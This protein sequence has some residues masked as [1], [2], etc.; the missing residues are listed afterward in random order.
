[1]MHVQTCRQ[2]CHIPCT[3][4]GIK[5]PFPFVEPSL[6]AVQR[7]AHPVSRQRVDIIGFGLL[8]KL[9][10]I[11]GRDGLVV[12]P[13]FKSLEPECCQHQQPRDQRDEQP[14][15]K[16]EVNTAKVSAGSRI[17]TGPRVGES[18]TSRTP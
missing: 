14:R 3:G 12:Q 9:E 11:G 1:V 5:R 10:H 13:R 7:A 2:T 16:G 4:P 18:R 17:V 8:E 6:H 15:H